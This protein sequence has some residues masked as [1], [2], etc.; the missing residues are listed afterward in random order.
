M[1]RIYWTNLP[2]RK[3]TIDNKQKY[4]R[5]GNIIKRNGICTG[6]T[7]E[8]QSRRYIRNSNR[9][10]DRIRRFKHRQITEINKIYNSA[11]IYFH[12]SAL[13]TR[14]KEFEIQSM[15]KIHIRILMNIARNRIRTQI[16]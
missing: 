8:K 16:G 6:Q 2:R 3:R 4:E 15:K 5:I 11:D 9:D 12:R 14:R 10:A 13:E 1:E 7:E